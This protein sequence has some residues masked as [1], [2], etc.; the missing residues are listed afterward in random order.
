M[1]KLLTTFIFLGVFVFANAQQNAQYTQFFANK[2]IQN[3]GYAGSAEVLSLTGLHRQ[4]WVGLEGAPIT[5][6]FSLHAPVFN[7][8]VGLG[9]SI[10]RDDITISEN[11]DI[12][13]SY[14]YRIKL[15][16]G[17]LSLG[18]QADLRFMKIKWDQVEALEINDNEIPN[19]NSQRFKPDIAAGIYYY[20]KRMYL[21]LAVQNLISPSKIGDL[22]SVLDYLPLDDRHVYLMGGYAFPISEN[23]DLAPVVLMKFVKNTPFDLDINASFIFYDKLWAGI[24]WRK[25]DSIDF[26]LQYQLNQQLKIGAAYDFTTSELQQVNSGSYEL[27]FQYD[28]NFKN[29]GFTNLRFF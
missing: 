3:P 7:K 16:E 21:G 20:T 24:S 9:L 27:M 6:T 26:V 5:Q 10:L 18:L 22:V 14:A 13:T 8:R 4:Q 23:V 12:I 17:T 29:S 25:D 19:L 1:K 11:W 2:L 15:D 28:F